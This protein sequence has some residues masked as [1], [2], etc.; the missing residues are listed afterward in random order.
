[1]LLRSGATVQLQ[2]AANVE[3][4]LRYGEAFGREQPEGF[5]R[6]LADV[7]CSTEG[8]FDVSEP[9]SYTYWKPSKVKEMARKQKRLIYSAVAAL[10]PGGVLVYS[11]CT[12]APEENEAVVDWA[13]KKFAGARA[14]EPVSLGF[15]NHLPGLAAWEKRAFDPSMKLARRI[16]PTEDMEGF[17]IAR[18]RKHAK[19]TSA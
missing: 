16:L 12:F 2:G 17:F 9:S 14:L 15:T 19:T 5:D 13:L 18:L 6:V 10:K 7:P 11:T 8:R 1:M 4:T 3:T